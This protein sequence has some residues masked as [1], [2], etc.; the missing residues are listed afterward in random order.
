[1]K[2]DGD[3]PVEA[4]AQARLIILVDAPALPF[5]AAHE[6][7]AEIAPLASF[8]E[9]IGEVATRLRSGRL[10]ALD[11]PLIVAPAGRLGEDAQE[12]TAALRRLHPRTRLVGVRTPGVE[13]DERLLA[14]LG[15][16]ILPAGEIEEALDLSSQAEAWPAP[17]APAPIAPTDEPAQGQA[18]V[19][20]AVEGDLP[21]TTQ[22][23]HLALSPEDEQDPPP[24]PLPA[25]PAGEP[26]PA[27]ITGMADER[28]AALLVTDV[29]EIPEA[30][31]E[32]LRQ[33][34]G[35]P[36]LRLY[37]SGETPTVADDEVGIRLEEPDGSALGV[38]VVAAEHAPLAYAWSAWLSSWLR[39]A[40]RVHRLSEEADLDPLTGAYNRRSLLRYLDESLVTAREKRQALTVMVFDVD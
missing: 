26:A 39:A 38:L 18:E 31:Q 6:G 13:H 24:D 4:A 28:L 37:P 19:S 15:V 34:L 12:V 14:A 3:K 29:A 8:H 36:S 7:E 27:S 22:E 11:E 21:P 32:L 40:S 20:E 35:L 2:A 30:C 16:E 5:H 33:R 1:M 23:S 25:T 9:A 10:S 17:D